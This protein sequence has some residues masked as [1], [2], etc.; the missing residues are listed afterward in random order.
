M[1]KFITETAELFIS[2]IITEVVRIFIIYIDSILLKKRSRYLICKSKFR[3]LTA[4]CI[5][6]ISLHLRNMYYLYC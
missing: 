5:L 4:T 6:I 1:Y 2:V 3:T